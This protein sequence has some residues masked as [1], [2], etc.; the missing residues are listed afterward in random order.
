M[1]HLTKLTPLN[2]SALMV[3]WKD[4]WVQTR[5]GAC[6]VSHVDPKSVDVKKKKVAVGSGL[7]NDTIIWEK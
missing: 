2:N 7:F 6:I 1:P 3:I 5:A 4:L